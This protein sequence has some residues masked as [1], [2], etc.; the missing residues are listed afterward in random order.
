MPSYIGT[1]G[2]DRI[3]TTGGD[4]I[5]ALVEDA[6]LG[7]T[8]L[9]SGHL[10][11]TIDLGS[12]DLFGENGLILAAERHLAELKWELRICEGGLWKGKAKVRMDPDGYAWDYLVRRNQAGVARIWWIRDPNDAA[13]ALPETD[14]LWVGLAEDPKVAANSRLVEFTLR[15]AGELLEGFVY[16]G[17]FKGTKIGNAAQTVLSTLIGATGSPISAVDV[18]LGGICQRRF[19]KEYDNTPIDRVMKDL[20]EL[21]GGTEMI[22]WGA[23]PAD[24]YEDNCVAYFQPFTGHL[25]EKDGTV[26]THPRTYSVPGRAI[27]Q[28]ELTNISSDIR[29]RIIVLGAERPRSGINGVVRRFSAFAE[30]RESVIR[31]GRRQKIV[32]DSGLKTDGQCALVAAG[33]VQELGNRHLELDAKVFL[34]LQNT[35]TEGTLVKNLLNDTLMRPGRV[36]LLRNEANGYVPWG[37]SHNNYRATRNAST[38]NFLR[39]RTQD[40]PA[41]DP[42]LLDLKA[43][44]ASGAARL[45]LFHQYRSA[46]VSPTG[47]VA[48]AE[49]DRALSVGWV[50]TSPGSAVW[51]LRVAYRN[52]AHAWTTL[53]TSASSR[54]TAQLAQVHTVGLEIQRVDASNFSVA[55]HFWDAAGGAVTY[56]AATNLAHASIS[57]TATVNGLY[58]NAVLTSGL[59]SPTYVGDCNT[60]ATSWVAAWKAYPT[61]P[62]FLA[63]IGSGR[64]PFKRYPNMVML[65]DFG[66]LDAD[67]AAWVRWAFS[68][69]DVLGEFAAIPVGLA[70]QSAI[71]AAVRIF[72]C[73]NYS[74]FLGENEYARNYGTH[75]EMIP[76]EVKIDWGGHDA[77]LS[78]EITGEVGSRGASK[79]LESLA[80]KIQA[81]EESQRTGR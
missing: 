73:R 31:F 41:T 75:P 81:A 79:I 30:A 36:L 14:L 50:E 17:E 22:A 72:T 65:T 3:I 19:S 35:P 60:S 70:A 2:G 56:I 13:G 34:N 20:A 37:D 78:L 68:Q 26:V 9:V 76:S 51:N 46:M 71:D 62:G 16:T 47:M 45:Y 18:E 23:R 40:Q 69:T 63:S 39:I 77:P 6:A 61:L 11:L 80:A 58:V 49:L 7:A 74:W 66:K 42:A 27:H 32:Q 24:D 28:L 33:K 25:Y 12:A 54:T 57:S 21:A 10:K 29:N 43:A 52:A 8:G 48:V 1:T 59:D 64:P 38:A 15:G 67:E 55:V 5:L 44:L 53:A 4:P